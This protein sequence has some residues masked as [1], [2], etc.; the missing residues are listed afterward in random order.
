MILPRASTGFLK[1]MRWR[2]VHRLV[3]KK[4]NKASGSKLL[5]GAPSHAGDYQSG[6][7]APAGHH[8]RM[9]GK[10]AEKRQVSKKPLRTV[11]FIPHRFRQVGPGPAP[12]E[13]VSRSSSSSA[14]HHPVVVDIRCLR[15]AAQKVAK[16]SNSRQ[17]CRTCQKS[18]SPPIIA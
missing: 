11:R 9:I 6:R 16:A 1:L 2:R 3:E 10:S 12:R 14:D 17:T 7:P 4:R 18:L 15:A 8:D 13:A 5:Y